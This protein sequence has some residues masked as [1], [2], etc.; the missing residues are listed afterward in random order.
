[1]YRFLLK[2][3]YFKFLFE[4]AFTNLQYGDHDFRVNARPYFD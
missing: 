1:M 4:T 2:E 3:L